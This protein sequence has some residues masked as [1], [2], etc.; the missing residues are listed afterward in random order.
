MRKITMLLS[1]MVLSLAGNLSLTQPA[2][3]ET[4]VQLNAETRLMVAL[5]VGQAE[6]QKLVPA[7][8]QVMSL[9][10]GPQQGRP[11]QHGSA[12]FLCGVKGAAG[13]L[14]MDAAL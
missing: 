3:A 1:I 5:R 11:A 6:L 10:A 12:R 8:W 2:C 9:P 13:R 14:K 7:S 4:L